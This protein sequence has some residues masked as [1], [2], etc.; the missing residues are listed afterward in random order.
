MIRLWVSADTDWDFEQA[1]EAGVLQ[2]ADAR[3]SRQVLP[4]YPLRP[5]TS[6]CFDNQPPD[7]TAKRLVKR[8]E[9]LGD[10]VI[11]RQAETPAVTES[12]YFQTS[13]LLPISEHSPPF[14]S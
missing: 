12:S 13:R 9:C 8:I 14:C 7:A 1:W 10:A 2:G 3:K 4:C 6:P 11:L 5:P